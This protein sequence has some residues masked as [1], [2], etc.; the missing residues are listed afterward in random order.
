MRGGAALGE[1]HLAFTTR[2][3]EPVKKLGLELP[4]FFQRGNKASGSSE[5]LAREEQR[6][7][8]LAEEQH[9]EPQGPP[10]SRAEQLKARLASKVDAV[11]GGAEA[12]KTSWSTFGSG[13]AAG[14]S[15]SGTGA[16]GSSSA[17]TA[18]PT[19]AAAAPAAA[20]PAADK[21]AAGDS[22]DALFAN[23]GRR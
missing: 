6:T 5:S 21:A 17:A 22:L 23:L 15:G 7:S 18:P 3:R 16:S 11:K 19:R 10:L 14:A 9:V 8:L 20:P 13:S 12:K 2:R 1:T 4:K